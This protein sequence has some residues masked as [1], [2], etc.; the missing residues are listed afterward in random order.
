M[1]LLPILC[2]SKAFLKTFQFAQPGSQIDLSVKLMQVPDSCK[3]QTHPKPEA[4][5][6]RLSTALGQSPPY[7]PPFFFFFPPFSLS[8]P[9][10]DSVWKAI[11]CKNYV[12]EICHS[13]S[14]QNRK[15]TVSQILPVD[16]FYFFGNICQQH[17]FQCLINT[18]LIKKIRLDRPTLMLKKIEQIIKQSVYKHRG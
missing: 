2:S 3:C 10:S 12:N 15:F 9:K 17:D 14:I 8:I 5:A 7:P 13:L 11:S 16:L 18:N 1:S 6:G 4:S